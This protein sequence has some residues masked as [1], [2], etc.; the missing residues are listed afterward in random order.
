MSKNTSRELVGQVTTAERDE[1]MA[2]H[3]RKNALIELFQTIKNVNQ[4][5][6]SLYERIVADMGKTTTKFNDWWQNTSK[7]H[8][9]QNLPGY[10]WEIDFATCDI[11]LVKQN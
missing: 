5:D 8:G 2:L 1:I 9:W 6:D 7:K 10:N 4:E 11:Y 3:E